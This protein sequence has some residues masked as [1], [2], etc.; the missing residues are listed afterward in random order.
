MNNSSKI[1][2]V[3]NMMPKSKKYSLLY[4]QISV[5]LISLMELTGVFTLYPLLNLILYPSDESWWLNTIKNT[6]SV[7]SYESVVI[8]TGLTFIILLSLSNILRAILVYVYLNFCEN[9]GELISVNLYKY[10]LNQN[11]KFIISKDTSE[12]V[13][14]FMQDIPRFVS[15]VLVPLL[16]IN[17]Q[18]LVVFLLVG[19]LI[20]LNPISAIC[21]F[22]LIGLLYSLTII[23]ARK[24]LRRNSSD[25]SQFS[26]KRLSLLKEGF[27][28]F[29]WLKVSKKEEVF[30]KEFSSVISKIH[31]IL[32]VNQSVALIPRY[33]LEFITIIALA[34]VGILSYLYSNNFLAVI[35]Q[36]GIFGIAGL[37]LL[38]ALQQIYVGI[39]RFNA[40]NTVIDT[41]YQP[42]IEANNN[43]NKNVKNENLINVNDFLEL[44]DV[45]FSYN[46]NKNILKKINLIIKKGSFNVILGPS[47]SGK[48]TLI[49][50]IL[51]I[52]EPSYGEFVIDGKKIELN[53]FQNLN[54]K[55]TFVPQEIFLTNSSISK[56]IVFG[57]K[58]EEQKVIDILKLVDLWDHVN[59]NCPKGIHELIGENGINLS[60][61]QKQKIGLARALYQDYSF[62]IL[63]ESTNSIDNNSEN[64]IMK[65]LRK[66]QNLTLIEI[67]H[68][69]NDLSYYDSVFE[70]DLGKLNKIR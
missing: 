47:G 56:N 50:V 53:K 45:S 69:K 20:I 67:S 38:P 43:I 5:I 10:Y 52:V 66:L 37:K 36:I 3:I 15:Q 16:Q 34:F 63:D 35:P 31:R 62:L 61:G 21:S 1:K 12:F 8:I 41:L 22:I 24:S 27:G 68:K 46:S 19:S 58:F 64:K 40:N 7:D 48:T 30:H 44:K 23:F 59:N 11:Y 57:E 33:I 70:M 55:F 9:V 25:L 60:G 17:S 2:K 65:N 28:L 39:T 6:F 54:K 51:G 42:V 26:E 32:L 49:D 4:I 13:N 29:K 14:N 18:I